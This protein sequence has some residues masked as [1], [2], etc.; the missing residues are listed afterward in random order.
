MPHAP[1]TAQPPFSPDLP[2]SHPLAIAN[3]PGESHVVLAPDKAACQRIATFLGLAAVDVLSVK[4]QILASRGGLIKI[5]GDLHARVQPLCVISLEP[6]PISLNEPVAI[7]FAPAALIARMTQRAEAEEQ[8]DF[9]PPDELIGNSIDLG[10]VVT[11]FLALALPPYPRKPE[12]EF[13]AK[14]LADAPPPSPFAVLA[15]LKKTDTSP[16]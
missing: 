13:T 3:L 5:K 11:E 8:E 16:P 2:Y 12:A 6:F 7:E 14:A 15:A 4:V 9:E 1:D 10:A